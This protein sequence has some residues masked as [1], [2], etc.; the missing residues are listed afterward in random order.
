MRLLIRRLI[1]VDIMGNTRREPSRTTFHD[2]LSPDSPNLGST[3]RARLIAPVSEVAGEVESPAIAQLRQKLQE[4]VEDEVIDPNELLAV[5]RHIVIQFTAANVHR[6]EGLL[7]NSPLLKAIKNS[8]QWRGERSKDGTSVR[9]YQQ[10]TDCIIALIPGSKS[11]DFSFMIRVGYWS[12][13]TVTEYLQYGNSMEQQ[14]S[15]S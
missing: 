7:A 8:R 11:Q 1:S 10:Q 9:P 6:L 15:A 5:Q 4:I 2:P 13:W 12:G 14:A 3:K